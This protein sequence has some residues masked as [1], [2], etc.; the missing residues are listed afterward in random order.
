MA[1]IATL[2]RSKLLKVLENQRLER[3]VS[4]IYESTALTADLRAPRTLGTV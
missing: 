4:G 1:R 2:E 3:A